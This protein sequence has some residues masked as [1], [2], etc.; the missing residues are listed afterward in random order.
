MNNDRSW[1]LEI[2][3]PLTTLNVPLVLRLNCDYNDIKF[4]HSMAQFV[5]RL[6]DWMSVEGEGN[7]LIR[8]TSFWYFQT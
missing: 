5:G 8:V 6:L 1:R 2:T 3:W 7:S 4:S